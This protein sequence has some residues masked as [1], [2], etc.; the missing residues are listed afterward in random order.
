MLDQREVKSGELEAAP[1][2]FVASVCLQQLRFFA[3]TVPRHSERHD[4]ARCR[5]G[6]CTLGLENHCSFATVAFCSD[7]PC[8]SLELVDHDQKVD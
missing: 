8:D 5:T 3:C 4:P 6:E 1:P 7:V 2:W